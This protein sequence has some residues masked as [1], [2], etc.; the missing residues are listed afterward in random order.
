MDNALQ[1]GIHLG[2]IGRTHVGQRH[3]FSQLAF[4][5]HRRF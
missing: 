1:L 3:A 4:R 5:L 2:V